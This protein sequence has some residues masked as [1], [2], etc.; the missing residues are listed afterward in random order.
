MFDVFS[1]S[2][3]ESSCKMGTLLPQIRSTNTL[4]GRGKL[5]LERRSQ[6]TRDMNV[7]L[8]R[9]KVAMTV[10]NGK[11]NSVDS[12][13]SKSITLGLN[14]KAGV[15]RLK[16]DVV[17]SDVELVAAFEIETKSFPPKALR[18]LIEGEVAGS[19]RHVV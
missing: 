6:A 18:C 11:E 14:L 2:A 13:V 19:W 12:S 16:H 15:A 5:E 4:G 3:K 17:V 9:T 1:S 7:D 8:G 10:G